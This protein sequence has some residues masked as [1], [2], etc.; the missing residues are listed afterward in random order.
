MQY[1]KSLTL[2]ATLAATFTLGPSPLFQILPASAQDA[3]AQQSAPAQS[4]DATNAAVS[5]MNAYVKFLNRS[6]RASD[7][8]QRYASWVNM[9]KGPTGKEMNIY[10]LYSL[11]DVHDEI[12]GVEQA[13]KADPKLPDLDAAMQAYVDIYQQ[14]APVIDKADKYYERSDYKAD[15]MAGGKAMHKDIAALAPI[16]EQRRQAVDAAL[17]TEKRKVDLA[18]LDAIEKRDGKNKVWQVRN[19]MMH[20]EALVD[21]LPSN[22]KPVVDLPP[23]K[24]ALDDYA[25][26]TKTFDDFGLAHPNAFLTFEDQPDSLLSKLRDLYETL[27]KVKGDARKGGGDDLENIV[28]DYNMMVSTSDIAAESFPN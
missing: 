2:A 4:V 9:K 28:D 18:S 20:A 24:T 6:L 25:D 16:Y 13:E 10:G 1:L 12:A 7:S 8:L 26:A 14:L 23:F 17:K 15:K 19:V 21:M 5:K 11:Y 22:E 3:A 27:S